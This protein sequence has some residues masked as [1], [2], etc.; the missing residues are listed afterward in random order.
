MEAVMAET[1]YPNADASLM[2][3][4]AQAQLAT[5]LSFV[6][7]IDAKLGTFLGWASGLIAIYAAFLALR[8]HAFGPIDVLLV[9]VNLG[10]YAAVAYSGLRGLRPYAWSTG[11]PLDDLWSIY[12]NQEANLKWR[13]AADFYNYFEENEPERVRKETYL[14]LARIGLIVQT[15]VTL[16]GIALS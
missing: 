3:D 10:A 1:T 2:L 9:G 14:R 4:L 7:A 13:V 11:P 12:E 16:F 15:G 6:D 5:Q 8:P